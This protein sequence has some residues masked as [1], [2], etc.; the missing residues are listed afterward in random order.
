MCSAEVWHLVICAP[1]RHRRQVW[2]YLFPILTQIVLEHKYLS[3]RWENPVQPTKAWNGQYLPSEP[4]APYLAYAFF[5]QALDSH[6]Y[7]AIIAQILGIKSP[8]FF[9]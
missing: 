8:L 2:R 1:V 9:P 4:P 3:Q 5:G 6:P 7:L